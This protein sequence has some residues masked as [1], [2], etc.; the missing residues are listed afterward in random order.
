MNQFSIL[1]TQQDILQHGWVGQQYVGWMLTQFGTSGYDMGVFLFNDIS[2][3]IPDDSTDGINLT[4]NFLVILILFVR[5]K[6]RHIAIVNRKSEICS[7]QQFFHTCLLI[8]HQCIERVEEDGLYLFRYMM[9]YQILYKREHETLCLTRT[10]SCCYNDTHIFAVRSLLLQQ[11]FPALI[12]VLIRWIVSICIRHTFPPECTHHF[13]SLGFVFCINSLVTVHTLYQWHSILR[14]EY[15]RDDHLQLIDVSL[16]A[17]V[18]CFTAPH[19]SK[20]FLY[21]CAVIL[22]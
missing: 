22:I 7:C 18:P 10:S 9:F 19:G 3:F 21:C 2:I 17:F 13:F 11:S 4:E 15:L 16:L 8:L 12:L 20:S 1:I 5:Q 6:L 14:S